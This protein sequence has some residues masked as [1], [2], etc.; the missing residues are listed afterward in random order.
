M[1]GG[2]DFLDNIIPSVIH[3]L[4]QPVMMH[5]HSFNVIY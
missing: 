2:K 4:P 5:F 1:L 3:V